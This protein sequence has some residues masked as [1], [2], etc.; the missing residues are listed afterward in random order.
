MSSDNDE[1][2]A[3][4]A[5]LMGQHDVK[6]EAVGLRAN[7]KAKG[8]GGTQEKGVCRSNMTTRGRV[9]RQVG[10]VRPETRLPTH[11]GRPILGKPGLKTPAD[12]RISA[13]SRWGVPHRV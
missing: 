5:M 12:S 9:E 7:S 2:S 3:G 4:D 11:S 1:P 8:V 10:F 13:S 6:S